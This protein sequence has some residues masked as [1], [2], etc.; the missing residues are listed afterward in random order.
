MVNSLYRAQLPETGM[1]PTDEDFAAWGTLSWCRILYD[2]FV[3]RG[4]R[5]PIIDAED[6]IYNTKP[7]TDKLCKV[8]GIDPEGV[9]E[10]WDPLPKAYWPHHKMAVAFTGELM[11]SSGIERRAE[12]VS[13]VFSAL[14]FSHEQR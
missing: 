11:R 5:P 12:Q 9:K 7:T 3:S 6:V 13:L 8:L 14:Y 1:Q 4:H 10:T 2:Y